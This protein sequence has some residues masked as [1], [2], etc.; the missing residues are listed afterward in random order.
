MNPKRNRNNKSTT[1]R[2][3]M[4][5]AVI[6]LCATLARATVVLPALIADNMV[7]Q[8]QQE[9]NLWGTAAPGEQVVVKASWL[10]KPQV[11]QAGAGGHWSVKIRTTKAGGPY[12]IQF[13]GSNSITVNNVL[14][15][16][17]WLAS[18]QS[19]MEFPMGK[20]EGWRT[21]VV[22]YATEL[23]QA[24]YPAI[25]MIDVPNVVADSPLS[26]FKGTW[27]VCT[28]DNAA[29]FSAVAY[30]FARKV[31]Q[32]TG[33]P[34]GMINATWGGTPA[35]SWTRKEVLESSFPTIMERYNK[36]LETYP[37][38]YA[39]YQ[40]KMQAWKAD[41]SAGRKGAPKEPVGPN[42]NKSPYKLYN[43][44]IHPLLYYACKGVI[45]YQGESNAEYAW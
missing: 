31:Q 17:V 16:E 41:T 30:Y 35:E 14:L 33:A 38:R 2:R 23:A 7:L 32:E 37:E 8:Q 15:G 12:R 20:G 28:P 42:H 22:D 39:Q 29:Q 45:W 3:I 24:N 44:M 19:N 25:R 10:T 36:T 18:G 6:M 21:G 9:V 26:D 5:A 43:A 11:T 4:M 27:A 1:I 40:Q 13:S 34:I